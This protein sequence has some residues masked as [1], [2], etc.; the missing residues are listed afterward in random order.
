MSR[1]YLAK[2]ETTAIVRQLLLYGKLTMP[3]IVS[4]IGADD[5]T[6]E[7]IVGSANTQRR[8]RYVE[9]WLPSSDRGSSSL[10]VQSC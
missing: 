9:L 7:Y 3:E 1:K 4:V 10:P 5:R 6:R 8:M 2:L